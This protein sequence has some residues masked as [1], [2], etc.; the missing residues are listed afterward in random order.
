MLN[1]Y[2]VFAALLVMFMFLGAYL[3]HLRKKKIKERSRNSGHN[4]LARDL[5][6]WVGSRRWMYGNWRQAPPPRQ[7]GLNELG[8]APPPYKPEPGQELPQI[9]LQTLAR[10][11]Q[12]R[13]SPPDYEAVAGHLDEPRR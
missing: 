6:G 3:L 2:F 5:D 4:A 13:A 11:P 10:D 9:P 8:E 1:Y 7:E 12:D